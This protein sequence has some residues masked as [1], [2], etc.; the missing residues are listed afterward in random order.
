MLPSKGFD[1]SYLDEAGPSLAVSIGLAT[2][3]LDS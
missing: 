1:P 3:R 2:R